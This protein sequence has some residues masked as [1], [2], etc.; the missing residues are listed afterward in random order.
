M[1]CIV[2]ILMIAGAGCMSKKSTDSKEPISQSDD[3]F[4]HGYPSLSEILNKSGAH[5]FSYVNAYG[6]RIAAID[7][8]DNRYFYIYSPHGDLDRII[9]ERN[10]TIWI[11]SSS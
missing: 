6:K 3:G 11:T 10:K 4:D 7:D 9:D 2:L 8:K 1:L 5:S